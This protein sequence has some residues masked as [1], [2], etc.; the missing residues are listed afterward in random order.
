MPP[1]WREG[2]PTVNSMPD[3]GVMFH[4]IRLLCPEKGLLKPRP[5]K[6]RSSRA[7]KHGGGTWSPPRPRDRTVIRIASM[8]GSQQDPCLAR[9]SGQTD[10]T[11]GS[12]GGMCHGF[13]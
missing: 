12:A 7:P 10:D 8:A 5:G 1:K 4:L 11:A 6:V 2:H 9:L 3:L 13:W